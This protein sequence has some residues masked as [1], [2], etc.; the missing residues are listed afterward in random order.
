[1]NDSYKLFSEQEKKIIY[2][3]QVANASQ[4]FLYKISK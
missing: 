3:N 1:M 4:V 2:Q